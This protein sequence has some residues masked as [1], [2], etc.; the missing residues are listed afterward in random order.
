MFPTLVL[1]F[2]VVALTGESHLAIN[3]FVFQQIHNV[4]EQFSAVATYQDVGVTCIQTG[5]APGQ[6]R[7][8]HSI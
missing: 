2:L 6:G 3:L 7:R 1:L 8:F 4:L 5:V